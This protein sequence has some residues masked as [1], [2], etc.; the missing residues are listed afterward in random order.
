MPENYSRGRSTHLDRIYVHREYLR[1][2]PEAED[3]WAKKYGL[4]SENGWLLP[5][6]E[7][8]FFITAS[9]EEDKPRT[10]S[11][12]PENGTM[13]RTR[14]SEANKLERTMLSSVTEVSYPH[15]FAA[16]EEMRKWKFLQLDLQAL[17]EPSKMFVPPYLA[18][19]GANLSTVLNRMNNE[20]SYLLPNMGR[21][22]SILVPGIVG[23]E[24]EN[25][26]E[27]ERYI[28]RAKTQDGRSF[29]APVLSDGTLRMLA[30]ATLKNN[31]EQSGL[32]CL[33]EPENGVHPA[34]FKHLAH[35][36]TLMVTDFSAYE[37]Q[38]EPLRQLLVNTHSPTFV[39]QEEVV[40]NL[41]VA[42][43]VSTF[44]GKD[45]KVPIRVTRMEPVV[46]DRT[47][48]D[49]A[50]RPEQAYTLMQVIR[51]LNGADLNRA[52]RKLEEVRL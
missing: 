7:K 26:N 32:L 3:E 24:I 1:T 34:C 29:A 49:V 13:A 15:V 11:L 22:L 50:L 10:I 40:N 23:V 8:H 43:G 20:A 36:F 47:K 18:E 45:T 46:T 48:Q 17:R 9:D 12:Y 16:R 41:L 5:K 4:S 31:P 2:I 33:E 19:D 35:L 37:E 27:R 25:D 52:R 44:Y 14:I 51:Y 30:L 39:S 6:S 42:Y 28:V 38:Q 21:D